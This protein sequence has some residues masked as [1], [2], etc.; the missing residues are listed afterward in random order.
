MLRVRFARVFESWLRAE[1][2]VGEFLL[3]IDALLLAVANPFEH[4]S[5]L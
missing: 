2:C 3:T 4:L 1:D 5:G